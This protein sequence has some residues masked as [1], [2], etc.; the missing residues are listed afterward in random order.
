MSQFAIYF[1]TDNF[2]VFMKTEFVVD[3]NTHKFLRGAIFHEKVTYF[4][5]YM[6]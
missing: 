4:Y 5:F 3:L 6:E 2:D 1:L